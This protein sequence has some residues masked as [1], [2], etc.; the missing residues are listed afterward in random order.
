MCDLSAYAYY[1]WLMNGC[2][3]FFPPY[4]Q[5]KEKL[6]IKKKMR[7][8][9]VALC[10][11]NSIVSYYSKWSY[12]NLVEHTSAKKIIN[13]RVHFLTSFCLNI[14]VTEHVILGTCNV[15]SWKLVKLYLVVFSII[16]LL[17]IKICQSYR[18][19]SI[20]NGTQFI[21]RLIPF[22]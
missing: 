10:M 15:T 4:H 2:L 13:Y 3:F 8:S 16:S 17:L 5:K 11:C 22:L 6:K 20:V 18:W 12:L 1:A 7:E 14:L 19:F 21:L 9:T